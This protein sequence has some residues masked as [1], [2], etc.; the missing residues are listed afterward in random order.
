MKVCGKDVVPEPV[1]VRLRGLR[2]AWY[3][4]SEL[5]TRETVITES[6][7]LAPTPQEISVSER[8]RGRWH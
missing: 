3:R 6:S 2:S 7:I 1:L 5:R 8:R 4:P